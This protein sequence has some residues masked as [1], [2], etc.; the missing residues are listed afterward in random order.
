MSFGLNA[1]SHISPKPMCLWSFVIQG[2]SLIHKGLIS[3]AVTIAHCEALGLEMPTRCVAF[4][5]CK[6]LFEKSS[7]TLVWLLPH[8]SA[9]HHFG[10]GQHRPREAGHLERGALQ[11]VGA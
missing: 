5:C 4:L 9:V 11:D 1:V 2:H 8:D 3:I 6:C 10:G 7:L